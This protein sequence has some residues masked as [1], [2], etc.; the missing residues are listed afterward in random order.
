MEPFLALR[1]APWVVLAR[2]DDPW[3]HTECA[4]LRERGG[5]LVRLDGREMSDP[6][7]VFRAF[8]REFSFPGYFGHN[9]D[10]LADCLHD[11]HGHGY[12]GAKDDTVV[13]IDRADDLHGADFLGLLVSVL[14]QAAWQA[15]LQ[16]DAD[17]LPNG[18]TPFPLHFV[19]LLHDLPPAALAAAVAT[20]A[21]VHTA[22]DEG[23]LTATLAGEDWPGPG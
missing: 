13:L 3:P 16:L 19:F 8:A 17:G 11:W 6:R 4:A 12:G 9:W 14:C 7:A 20:G 15:N 18:R 2:Y 1:R 5:R 21:D 23:R 22:F 10:A